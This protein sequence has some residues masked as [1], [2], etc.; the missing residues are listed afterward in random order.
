MSDGSEIEDGSLEQLV[1]LF[2]DR[3][4]LDPELSPIFTDAIDDWPH[5]LAKLVD[6]WSSVMLTTGRYKG[7]PVL[8]HL[9]HRDRIT[10]ELFDR[11]LALWSETTSQYMSAAAAAALQL[12]AVRIA[13]SLKLALFFKLEPSVSLRDPVPTRQLHEP[14]LSLDSGTGGNHVESADG[15]CGVEPNAACLPAGLTAYRRTELFTETSV[16]PGLLKDHSTKAGTWGLIHVFEGRLRYRITDSR[17][18][19]YE[20]VLTPDGRLGI[21]EPTILHNI[22]PLESVRF[23]VEFFRH[24]FSVVVGA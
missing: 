5:H 20:S 9:K 1:P 24:P 17:R 4:R 22:E 3:V 14:D 12:K 18:L 19:P 8:A 23:Q 11:W 2:Y 6:F 16:P 21:V 10:P 7:N 15:P 13:E